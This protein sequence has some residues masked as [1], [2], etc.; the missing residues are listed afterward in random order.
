MRGKGE[1]NLGVWEIGERRIGGAWGRERK[2]W[3]CVGGEDWGPWGGRG[4]GDVR[5]S[6]DKDLGA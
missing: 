4:L 6:R 2:T 3:G 5:G 1:E